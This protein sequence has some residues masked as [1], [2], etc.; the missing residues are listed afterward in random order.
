MESLIQE[1]GALGLSLIIMFQIFNVQMRIVKLEMKI[2]S[3]DA[4]IAKLE[5]CQLNCKLKG[6]SK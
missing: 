6:K 5:N 2:D 1:Y 3:F 4:R